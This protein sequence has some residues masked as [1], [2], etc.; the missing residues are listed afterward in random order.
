MDPTG[1]VTR[2][3]LSVGVDIVGSDVDACVGSDVGSTVGVNVV[4]ENVSAGVGENV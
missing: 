3:E 1:F 2:D 4:G